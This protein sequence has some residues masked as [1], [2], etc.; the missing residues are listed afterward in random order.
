LKSGEATRPHIFQLLSST[1]DADDRTHFESRRLGEKGHKELGSRR[2]AGE[3]AVNRHNS[4]DRM[5]FRKKMRDVMSLL[6]RQKDLPDIV[7]VAKGGDPPGYGAGADRND[8]PGPGDCTSKVVKVFL[9]PD[10]AADQQQIHLRDIVRRN[11]QRHIGEPVI[12]YPLI[13]V[14]ERDFTAGTAGKL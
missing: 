4:V 12:A 14:K 10:P 2:A 8:L 6:V 7:P 3:I 5:A 11:H 9:I 1:F 13:C